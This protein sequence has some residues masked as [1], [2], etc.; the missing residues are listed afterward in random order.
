MNTALLLIAAISSAAGKASLSFSHLE[1][2]QK[3]TKGNSSKDGFV[4][5]VK[6]ALAVHLSP[7]TAKA[8]H[9]WAWQHKEAHPKETVSAQEETCTYWID[10]HPAEMLVHKW[11]HVRAKDMAASQE[12]G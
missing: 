6:P 10:A 8:T 12:G 4:N 1:S 9:G 7:R 3:S 11:I 2:Q 5:H